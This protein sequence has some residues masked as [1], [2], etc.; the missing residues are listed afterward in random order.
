MRHSSD[1]QLRVEIADLRREIRVATRQQA[2]AMT[3]GTI[4][5]WLTVVVPQLF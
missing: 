1:T 5:V 2:I 4:A 3:A